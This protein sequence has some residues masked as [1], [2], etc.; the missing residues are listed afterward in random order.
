[1]DFNELVKLRVYQVFNMAHTNEPSSKIISKVHTIYLELQAIQLE[2][3]ID[4][5]EVERGS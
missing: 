5:M 1:M 3:G 4:R 2:R